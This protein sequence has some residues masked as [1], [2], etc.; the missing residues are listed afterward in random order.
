MSIG[1]NLPRATT[2]PAG[3]VWSGW[4]GDRVRNH[5]LPHIEPQPVAEDGVDRR[6]IATKPYLQVTG[7]YFI[8]AAGSPATPTKAVQH[9]A[10]AA[11]N[12]CQT[13]NTGIR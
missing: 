13:R 11:R 5:P 12:R 4:A 6:V 10:G 8:A 9:P 3:R 7:G 1:S 2:L